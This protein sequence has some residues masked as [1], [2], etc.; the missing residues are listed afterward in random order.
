MN[1]VH[2]TSLEEFLNIA[3]IILNFVLQFKPDSHWVC[4]IKS[5]FMELNF[6]R[7]Q[8]ITM[9]VEILRNLNLVYF[10]NRE[11]SADFLPTV[12]ESPRLLC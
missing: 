10:Q 4:R 7:R 1:N 9:M 12:Q 11:V 3:R 5:T 2:E 8:V 6:W